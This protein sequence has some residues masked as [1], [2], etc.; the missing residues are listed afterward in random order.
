MLDKIE[1][2]RLLLSVS[3]SKRRIII[4]SDLRALDQPGWSVQPIR[5]GTGYAVVG[6]LAVLQPEFKLIDLP[7][8]NFRTAELPASRWTA[9]TSPEFTKCS[10]K[11]EDHWTARRTLLRKLTGPVGSG[12]LS[13]DRTQ[14]PV[15]RGLRDR[16]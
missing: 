14:H 16:R 12:I 4:P 6:K 8:S 15:Y 10:R 13:G 5:L 2:N 7:L 1:H 11:F 9:W 3:L